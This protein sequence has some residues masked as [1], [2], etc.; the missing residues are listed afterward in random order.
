VPDLPLPDDLFRALLVS[1]FGP[2]AIVVVG[3]SLINFV[4]S[5]LSA[6]RAGYRLTKRSQAV[7]ARAATRVMQMRPV[8]VLVGS[9]MTLLLIALQGLWLMTTYVAGNGLR[10][11][12]TG[13]I[14]DTGPEWGVLLHSMRWDKISAG[15]VVVC[16]VCIVL[17]YI[18]LLSGDDDRAGYAIVPAAP[19]ILFGILTSILAALALFLAALVLVTEHRFV[20]E[21]PG[22]AALILLAICITYTA[23]CYSALGVPASLARIWRVVGVDGAGAD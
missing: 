5:W 1:I 6:G 10:Y 17:A 20:L 3:Y 18:S 22:K 19:A 23:A 8:A 7:G 11:L 2:G 15:Y 9:L 14:P 4:W 16:G 13:P 12:V 21:P